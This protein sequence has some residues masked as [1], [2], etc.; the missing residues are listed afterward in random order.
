MT[1]ILREKDIHVA[2]AGDARCIVFRRMNNALVAV[3][4]IKPHNPDGVCITTCLFISINMRI[5]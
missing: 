4:L 1:A 5:A 2:W 3:P